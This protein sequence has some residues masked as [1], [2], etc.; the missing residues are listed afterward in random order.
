M[1][2]DHHRDPLQK[3]L[4]AR[5]VHKKAD[6]FTNVADKLCVISFHKFKGNPSLLMVAQ[7]VLSALWRIKQKRP[8]LLHRIIGLL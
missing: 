8:I 3:G 1:F 5:R 7:G 6:E 2:G 4:Q